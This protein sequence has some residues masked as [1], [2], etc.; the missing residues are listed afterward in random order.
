MKTKNNAPLE[1]TLGNEMITV[2]QVIN[3]DDTVTVK[4]FSYK[5]TKQERE[6]ELRRICH[7]KL[8]N[9]TYLIEKRKLFERINILNIVFLDTANSVVVDELT[10]ALS[11]A[12]EIK[13]NKDTLLKSRQVK[14]N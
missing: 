8:E 4:F 5:K 6:I 12:I 7:L 2:D 10:K 11:K 3:D 14:T 1:I 9:D 13:N